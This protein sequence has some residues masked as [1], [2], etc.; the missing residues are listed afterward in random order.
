MVSPNAIPGQGSSPVTLSLAPS[1]SALVQGTITQALTPAAP[2]PTAPLIGFGSSYISANPSGEYILPDGQTL[3]GG[4][5]AIVLTEPGT[6]PGAPSSLLTVSLASANSAIVIGSVTHALALPDSGTITSNGVVGSEITEAPAISVGGTAVSANLLGDY[7]LPDGQT[8]VPG[9]SAV[10]VSGTTLS[11]QSGDKG[12]VVGN[13]TQ[14]LHPTTTFLT[15]S[16]MSSFNSSSNSST[17]SSS[18]SNSGFGTLTTPSS[19]TA[20]GAAS[21]T[22]SKK[23]TASSTKWM[24]GGERW[25]LWGISTI[26]IMWVAM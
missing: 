20:A 16:I 6:A 9:G 13:S 21:P 17:S 11:L 14:K 15:A 26:C 24:T 5:S 3:S 1:A 7:V 18:N 19:T 12:L 23:G 22:A 25:W 10:V 4:G 2:S 8:L